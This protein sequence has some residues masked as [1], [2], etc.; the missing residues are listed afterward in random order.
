M[1]AV[2]PDAAGWQTLRAWVQRH[3]E[4]YARYE[5]VFRAFQAAAES[6]DAVASGSSRIEQRNVAAVR[7]KLRTTSVPA[8]HVDAVIA[9]L[10]ECMTRSRHVS[11]ILRSALP[12][13]AY[14]VAQVDDALADL[15]HRTLFGLDED[16]NV[17]PPRRR[18]PPTVT[19]PPAAPP[20]DEHHG[21]LT[22]VGARTLANL[23]KAG[24]DVFVTRGYHATRVDDIVAAAGVSHG[25]FYRY[26]ENKDHL[27]R[28]LALHATQ[29]VVDAFNQIPDVA[30]EP[31]PAASSA[32]RQ[33]LRRYNA[34]YASETAMIRVWIDATAHDPRLSTES[35]A[36]VDWGRRRLVR[37]LRPRGFGDVETEALLMVALVD[38][39]GARRRESAIVEAAAH[40]IERG[41]LGS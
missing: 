11:G 19:A 10:L 12:R 6:D 17:R 16:V 29:T 33:W 23:R 5:P 22:R 14:P 36:A 35:A 38:S 13:T 31:G 41:L 3:G 4:I 39:F 37:F 24:H 2:G 15:V 7:A 28:A 34:A 32:L 1:E 30:G 27:V 21:E 20:D 25:V 9:V 8:R 18:P 26:F 40:V